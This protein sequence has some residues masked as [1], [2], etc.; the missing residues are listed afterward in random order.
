M[1][2]TY[3]FQLKTEMLAQSYSIIFRLLFQYCNILNTKCRPGSKKKYS[4]YL[5]THLEESNIIINHNELALFV[6]F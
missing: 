6:T 4:F 5:S 3:S 2:N 1:F